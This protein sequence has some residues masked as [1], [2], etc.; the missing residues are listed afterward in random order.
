M[1]N[2]DS[3]NG[4]E[5]RIESRALAESGTLKGPELPQPDTKSAEFGAMICNARISHN[6]KLSEVADTLRIRQVYLQAIEDGDFDD[7][8]GPTYAMGFVRTYSDYLGLDLDEV[9]QRYRSIT[10]DNYTQTA[11]GTPSLIVK[12]QLPT[13]FLLL[14][15][16]ILVVV[17]YSGWYYLMISDH[18]S[19]EV[20][21]KL[22]QSISEAARLNDKKTEEPVI[23]QVFKPSTK[24]ETPES[25]AADLAAEDIKKNRIRKSDSLSQ[26]NQTKVSGGSV[27]VKIPM[28]SG[29]T[30]TGAR[31]DLDGLSGNSPVVGLLPIQRNLKKQI[32]LRALVASWVELRD[33][34]GKR[35]LSRLLKGGEMFEVPK[36]SGILFT[37]GNAGG[38]EILVDG[39]PIPALG[40]LGAVRRNIP[41][42]PEILLTQNLGRR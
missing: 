5:A 22:P 19:N 17:A 26:N 24:A 37:T 10:G 30:S 42:D 41:M 8:P 16:A 39:R 34:G 18:S 9:M 32:V 15:G 38:I 2:A 40:P 29:V 35:L 31:T 1:K 21:T 20:V 11:L 4:I 14:V 33:A 6:Y 23:Q 28:I 27:L 36:R 25:S 3:F 12:A 13:G 7:L